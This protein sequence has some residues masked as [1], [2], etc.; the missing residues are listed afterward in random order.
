[1][2]IIILSS[3]NS[4]SGGFRQAAYLANGL[5]ADGHNVH[6]VCPSGGDAAALL[7]EMNLRHT[8]LPAT[9][10][11]A[12]KALRSLMPKNQPVIVHAFHNRG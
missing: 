11:K 2:N 8:A 7:K 3:S 4:T 12:D 10:R 5:Q 1:M 6:F 9:I